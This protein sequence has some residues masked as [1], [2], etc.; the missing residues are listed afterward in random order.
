MIIIKHINSNNGRRCCRWPP[1]E[2]TV[3]ITRLPS[4]LRT[5]LFDHLATILCMPVLHY[6]VSISLRPAI[7]CADLHFA[8]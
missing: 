1:A 3:V 8:P 6:R 4:E 7:F 2:D 5:I